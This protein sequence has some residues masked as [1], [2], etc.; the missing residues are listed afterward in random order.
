MSVRRIV[1]IL[2]GAVLG[3]SCAGATKPPP[4]REGGKMKAK[5]A[6]EVVMEEYELRSL[7][8]PAP[9]VAVDGLSLF[10]LTLPSRG[11]DNDRGIGLL[12]VPGADHSLAGADAMRAAMDRLK[13]L[14][15]QDDALL[16]ARL[17]SLFLGNDGIVITKPETE[18]PSMEHPRAVALVKPPRLDGD[19]VEYWTY[20]SPVERPGLKRSR[21]NRATLAFERVAAHTLIPKN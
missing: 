19:V 3:I 11:A 2:L 13:A 5:T 15:K 10:W 1:S 9:G 14:H 12:V 8:G 7:P 17:A 20:Q 21:F 18:V 4:N 6:A 16:V